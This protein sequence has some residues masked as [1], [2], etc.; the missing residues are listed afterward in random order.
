MQNILQSRP[1]TKYRLNLSLL[2]SRAQNTFGMLR[3]AELC[4]SSPNVTQELVMLLVGWKRNWKKH[5]TGGNGRWSA[6]RV[7]PGSHQSVSLLFS[8]FINVPPCNSNAIQP[9]LLGAGR[10]SQVPLGLTPPL[11]SGELCHHS[12]L[13]VEKYIFLFRLWI[14]LP[15]PAQL[16]LPCC[17]LTLG[18]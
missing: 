18:H 16:V 13:Q 4:P 9:Y 12:R 11:Q 15:E 6:P 2:L 8:Y 1:V 10:S 3:H 5:H 7:T 14:T 17:K